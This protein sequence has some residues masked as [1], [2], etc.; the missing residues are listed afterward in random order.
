MKLF[1]KGNHWSINENKLHLEGD[2][3]RV[4]KMEAV[5]E[6]RLRLQIYNEICDMKLLDNRNAIV[7]AGIDN[8]ALSVQALIADKVLGN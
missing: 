6:A 8:V 7:K 5:L 1:C 3:Q 4:A 2:L